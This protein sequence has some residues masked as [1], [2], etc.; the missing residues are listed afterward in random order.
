MK[1]IGG[2]AS[3]ISL[4]TPKS[5]KVRPT[6]VRAKKALFDSLSSS[7]LFQGKIVVDLFAGIGGLGLEAASRGAGKVYLV[8]KSPSH[9]KFAAANIEKIKRAGVKTEMQVLQT[10]VLSAPARLHELTGKIDLIFADPPYA[11]FAFFY[12][13]LLIDAKFAEWTQNALMIWE[14]P[15]DPTLELREENSLWEICNVR[16]FARTSFVFLTQKI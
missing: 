10:N 8:E 4:S 13:K 7:M 6:G 1:I 16:K 9:C 5:M 12:K 2:Q 11:K 15:D 14:Q 3:G